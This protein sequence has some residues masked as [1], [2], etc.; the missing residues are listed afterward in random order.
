MKNIKDSERTQ[1]TIWS[2]VV[3]F[4][5]PTALWND[6]KKSEFLD[7]KTFSIKKI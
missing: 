7:R 1:C 6:G 4:L 2:R 5:R 3:G